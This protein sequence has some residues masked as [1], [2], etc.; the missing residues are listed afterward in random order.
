DPRGLHDGRGYPS[1]LPEATVMAGHWYDITTLATATFDPA[2]H[3]DLLTGE[4]ASN[5]WELGRIYT[6]QLRLMKAA[7][8]ALPEEAPVLVGE[9]GLPF[10][11]D[12]G[13]SYMA[14]ARGE[15]GPHV[16]RKQI[17]A[18]DLMYDAMDELLLCCA[19]WNYTATNRND[20]RIGDGWNQE[21]LSIFSQDQLDGINDPNAGGR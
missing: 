14:W 16:W 4:Q 13:A 2:D 21:D 8:S 5:R 7:A 15:R 10:D 20:P 17:D 11:L 18:L 6:R 3:R 1:Q 9:F 12:Q 19:Q